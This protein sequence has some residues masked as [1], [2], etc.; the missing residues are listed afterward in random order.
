MCYCSGSDK[1]FSVIRR[2][3]S[4]I[5][6]EGG[7]YIHSYLCASARQKMSA[8]HLCG[9]FHLCELV[10]GQQMGVQLRLSIWNM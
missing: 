5:I 2:A 10:D 8:F 1:S 6:N 9:A 4:N 3:L 7:N